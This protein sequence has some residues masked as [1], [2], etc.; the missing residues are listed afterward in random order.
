MGGFS[1]GISQSPIQ[2]PPKFIP[3]L[4]EGVT[5]DFRWACPPQLAASSEGGPARRSSQRR[6][7]EG[8]PASAGGAVLESGKKACAR[9]VRWKPPAL[10]GGTGFQS[11]EKSLA[12]KW[13]ALAPGFRTCPISG[14]LNLSR[15][16][17][18][19]PRAIFCGLVRRS[20]LRRPKE[21]APCFSG[22]SRT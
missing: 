1:P 15:A 16:S 8:A 5:R 10:A 3:S 4:A 9:D 12:S 19:E 2:R 6:A 22:G 20:S 18:K 17:P 21:G 11:S 7:K 14:R 13:G